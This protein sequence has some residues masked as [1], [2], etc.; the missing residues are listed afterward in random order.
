MLLKVISVFWSFY[1]TRVET[2][3]IRTPRS[4]EGFTRLIGMLC[5]RVISLS[6]M[7][8]KVAMMV[9]SLF[10]YVPLYLLYLL[11][12]IIKNSNR[13]TRADP[14]LPITICLPAL[15]GEK[16][17][18]HLTSRVGYFFPYV[19]FLWELNDKEKKMLKNLK[20]YFD[21]QGIFWL[22]R[23]N[24]SL[25]IS[26]LS[27]TDCHLYYKYTSCR[28]SNDLQMQTALKVLSKTVCSFKD[29]KVLRLTCVV[30]RVAIFPMII[31]DIIKRRKLDKLYINIASPD[32]GDLQM[33]TSTINAI[34]DA[35]ASSSFLQKCIF[36]Y[37]DKS[38]S[39]LVECIKK[40]NFFKIPRLG[41]TKVLAHFFEG[42][43]YYNDAIELTPRP[44][45]VT[46][47]KVLAQFFE[48]A[49][50][51]N[52]TEL[53]LEHQPVTDEAIIRL[54]NFMLFSTTLRR[55]S[56]K[57]CTINGT[58][59]GYIANVLHRCRLEVLCLE[60]NRKIGDVGIDAL[61]S[62]LPCNK[63]LHVL[64][65]SNCGC[66]ANGVTNLIKSLYKNS[67][68]KK[69]YIALFDKNFWLISAISKLTTF[70]KTLSYLRIVSDIDFIG[71]I[72]IKSSDRFPSIFDLPIPDRA[73][74]SYGAWQIMKAIIEKAKKKLEDATNIATIVAFAPFLSLKFRRSDFFSKTY[75]VSDIIKECPKKLLARCISRFVSKLFKGSDIQSVVSKY[76]DAQL[77]PHNSSE[78]CYSK[79]KEICSERL[80]MIMDEASLNGRAI[81]RVYRIAYTKMVQSYFLQHL[82]RSMGTE[83]DFQI[84]RADALQL[85]NSFFYY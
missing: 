34:V 12:L 54:M 60:D 81:S 6:S 66:E 26:K 29:L 74:L 5:N 33:Q 47:E 30:D 19:M 68:L 63:T 42:V 72:R 1:P 10:L 11:I 43:I 4:E 38:S 85:L 65:I 15:R 67:S 37:T 36:S 79:L 70:N 2:A 14:P 80:G 73:C 77:S 23:M 76:I 32:N 61:A 31:S 78:E 20:L 45:P 82:I 44:Q 9:C 18:F 3:N 24:K 53:T 39:A 8:I 58:Q 55:L 49:P 51:N 27:I 21:E 16:A 25:P 71:Y 56:L 84:A 28:Y 64:K 69:L 35:V 17:P 57:S 22:N 52:I 62:V 7:I 48:K 75:E 13:F 41:F 59:M 46:G 50:D 83:K 40:E